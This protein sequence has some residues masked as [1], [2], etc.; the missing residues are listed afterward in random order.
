MNDL[1]E[2]ELEKIALDDTRDGMLF[3]FWVK[4]GSYPGGFPSET[5]AAIGHCKTPEEYRV[6]LTLLAMKKGVNLP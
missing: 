1:S 5:A 2:A 6:A 4:A 3:R